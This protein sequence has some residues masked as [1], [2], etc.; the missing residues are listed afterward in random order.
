MTA[1]QSHASPAANERVGPDSADVT[2]KPNVFESESQKA[3]QNAVDPNFVDVP[4][5]QGDSQ[6]LK[7]LEI[8]NIRLSAANE[9]I[10]LL[11]ERLKEKDAVIGALEGKDAVKTEMIDL[12]KSANKDRAFVNNGDARMLEACN[13]QL[14]KSE[15]RIFK[16]EH[17]GILKSIFDVKSATG[18]MMGYGAGRLQN[19]FTK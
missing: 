5:V 13:Q 11:N 4:A 8:A 12:L 9:T 16:L 2:K 3:Q 7:A 17:P 1:E 19:S 18:F 15:A 14:L 6:T 10:A